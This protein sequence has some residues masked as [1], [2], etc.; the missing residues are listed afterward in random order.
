ML[1]SSL[2]LLFAS[3]VAVN[4]AQLNFTAALGGPLAARRHVLE[5]SFGSCHALTALRG[6]YHAQLRSVKADIGPTYVRFHGLLDDDMSVVLAA[7]P[8]A[9]YSFFN[10]FAVFDFL[11]VRRRCPPES[12]LPTHFG[13]GGGL[14][15]LI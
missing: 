4:A 7:G 5:K 6:D 15:P 9:E 2:L 11:L 10:I 1:R 8:P 14:A 13:T 12:P 3:V